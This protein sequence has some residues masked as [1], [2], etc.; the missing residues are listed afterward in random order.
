MTPEEAAARLVREH[1]NQNPS[2][3]RDA[4]HRVEQSVVLFLASL[5][6]GVGERHVRAREEARRLA[7]R[8]EEEERQRAEEA[9]AAQQ[10]SGPSR[11]EAVDAT[12]AD[13][14]IKIER[15]DRPERSNDPGTSSGVETR[16]AT[17]EGGEL[18]NRP[19]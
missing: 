10:E 6:P 17:T 16:D 9:V 19:T 7:Q 15:P 5:I 14:E 18:R 3:W 1:E 13:S 8:L 12:V 4:F 2:I 11:E